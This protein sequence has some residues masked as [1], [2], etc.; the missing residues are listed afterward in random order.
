ML[1]QCL[2]KEVRDRDSKKRNNETGAA[3]IKNSHERTINSSSTKRGQKIFLKM[4]PSH[5]P[6]PSNPNINKPP[7]NLPIPNQL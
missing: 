5:F 3:T 4:I 1:K 6:S 2:F 7:P